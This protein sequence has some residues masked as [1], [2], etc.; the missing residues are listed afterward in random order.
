MGFIAFD[1][2]VASPHSTNFVGPVGPKDARIALIGEAPARE[3][4][5]QGK[6][7]VGP[8]GSVLDHCLHDAKLIRATCYITNFI[9]EPIG[10]DIER[11]VGKSGL[12]GLGRDWQ[13]SLADELANVGADILVPLGGPAAMAVAGIHSITASRGYITTALPMFGER[14]VLPTLHPASCLYGGN[15]INKYYI[16]HDLRKAARLL[17]NG[18]GVSE[19]TLASV[20]FPVTLREVDDMVQEM[21]D[22]GIFA[23]DIEVANYEVSCISFACSSHRS[24]SILLCQ[25]GL[26]SEDEELQ[27][28]NK[29]NQLFE[30]ES[31]CKVGQN[32]IFDSHFLMTHQNIYIRGPIVDTM[33]GHSLIYP[34]FLKGLGFLASIYLNI[35][36]WKDMVKFKGGNLKKE[37]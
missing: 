27:I 14:A 34:D 5:K 20:H 29:L 6:P 17:K 26:W 8:A 21:L 18:G 28:W 15:Y 33:I 19:V 31:V 35:P 24:Y 12:T 32:L 10:G 16:A 1:N 25:D 13:Q 11:Y 30:N 22:A 36:S 3:E 9:K 37:S 2:T 7:F 23:F 4:L